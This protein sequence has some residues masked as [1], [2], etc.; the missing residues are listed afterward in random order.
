MKHFPEPETAGLLKSIAG[1]VARK[2]EN[3]LEI[4]ADGANPIRL[5][6]E[7]GVI[8]VLSKENGQD[9]ILSLSEKCDAAAGSDVAWVLPAE[10]GSKEQAW[11][12]R[13]EGSIKMSKARGGIE[14]EVSAGRCELR[15][16]SNRPAADVYGNACLFDIKHG[17]RFTRAF[18]AFY[19]DTLLPCVIERT[20]AEHYPIRDGYVIS[21]LEETKYAGTYPDVDHEF[22]IKGRLA[23]GGLFDRAVARRMMELQFM[24]MKEDPIGL[25]RNPC[26]VQP[27]G[28][29]E[30]HVRR[31][32]LDG[33]TNAEMFLISG[34]VEVLESAWLYTAASGDLP[35][36]REHMEDLENAASLVESCIDQNG[37]L[38]SDVFYEDQ[39][40]KDGREC[41]SAALAAHSFGLLSGLEQL[42]GRSERSEHYAAVSRLLQE[43]LVNPLPKGFW[44][45][46]SGRF[47]DWVDRNGDVHDHIHL[48]ANIL[49]VLFGYADAEQAARVRRLLS[50]EDEKF[51]RFPS[52]LSSRIEDYSSSEMG[53]AGPYD[54][55]AAGR[56]WFWD[57]AY[58]AFGKE[59]D[60]LEEQLCKVASQAEKDGF[61]MGERYD[62]DYV[63]YIDHKNWHGASHYYEYPCVFLWVLIH[64]YIGIQFC[65]DADLRIAPEL[66]GFGKISLAGGAYA[67]AYEYGENAFVVQNL[68]G[69][70]RTFRL[71]LSAVYPGVKT[72][73]VNGGEVGIDAKIEIEAYGK[74]ELTVLR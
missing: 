62:M 47:A 69:R 39:V 49:P 55:C 54:L 63:Y 50:E 16:Y 52:F 60:V 68:A 43:A 34:N 13:T 71:D 31:N 74:A 57:A 56:Y 36:L 38:W 20:K 28:V 17:D 41:M 67:V 70:N 19:W 33:S 51:E 29:R 25:R 44:D 59:R 3:Y 15:P 5:L 10:I 32:S 21:T 64:D 2:A 65:M 61:L 30:Y 14:A 35:W 53:V 37:C 22:Q 46:D 58:R 23:T 27:D 1:S 45:E 42:I 26:A 73:R 4:R 7:N 9:F 48:L 11:M 24:V 66:T 40:I 18:S 72:W 6:F 12:I 8:Y